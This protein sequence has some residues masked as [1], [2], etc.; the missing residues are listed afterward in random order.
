LHTFYKSPILLFKL[1]KNRNTA[2]IL[3]IL[4]INLRLT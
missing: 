2:S 1:L 4:V 3:Q